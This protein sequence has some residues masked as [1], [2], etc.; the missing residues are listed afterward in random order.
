M[1]LERLLYLREDKDLRQIDLANI[2]NI[3]RVNISNWEN[4]REIIP[5]EKLNIYA[6]YFNTSFD[7]IFKF[8]NNK[9]SQIN[10]IE[11][12]KVEVGKRLKKVRKDNNVTQKELANILNTTQSTISA[13][14]SGKVLIL[15][16]FVYQICK[17]YNVS[18]DYLCGRNV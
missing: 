18:A 15:T 17:T 14:E 3:N 11:L 9:V 8:T 4:N 16:S 13:Y 2:L 1:N 12:D 10:N 7:Y 6:N 5:L